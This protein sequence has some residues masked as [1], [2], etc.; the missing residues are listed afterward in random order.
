MKQTNVK[1]G[2]ILQ[3][4]LSKYIE[5]YGYGKFLDPV[6][7]WGGDINLSG[8]ILIYHFISKTQEDDIKEVDRE[9]LLPPLAVSG[10]KGVSK[11][12][13]RVIGNEFITEE[14]TFL[15]HVKGGWPHLASKPERWLYYE[16]LGNSRKQH[17]A[18]Y[19]DVKHLEMNGQLN[20]ELIP[21]RI[22]MEYLKIRGEDI[23]S[24]VE[25]LNWLEEYEYNQS[26]D[27]PIYMKLPDKLKGRA[28][29]K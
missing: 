7:V 2:D 23:K 27:L 13:W 1:N 8:V 24:Q 28:I 5:G 3:I 11:L 10:I 22:A 17:F 25:E 29:V 14:E 16:E 6:K 21:F 19:E 4:P 20:I 12:G 15:P 26:K 9:L 18:D